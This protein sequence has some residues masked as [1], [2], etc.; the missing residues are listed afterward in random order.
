MVRLTKILNKKLTAVILA[1]AALCV[2]L[3]FLSGFFVGHIL[4]AQKISQI[5]KDQTGLE[6]KLCNSKISAMPDLS[7]LLS[8]KCLE[9]SLP[10]SNNAKN[11]SIFEGDNLELRVKIIPLLFK[12][13]SI[14]HFEANDIK[15]SV[16]R[17]KNGVF[18][19]EKYVKN[20][21]KFP[22]QLNFEKTA[23]KTLKSEMKF[24]D[25]KNLKIIILNCDKFLLSTS[26]RPKNLI[27]DTKGVVK[28]CDLNNQNNCANT[29]FTAFINTRLPF[30]KYSN[31]KNTELS[32][33]L[34]GFNLANLAPY[35]N[36]SGKIK[37]D[38]LTGLLDVSLLKTK[39]KQ[40][41]EFL[42]NVTSKD[43][44]GKFLYNKKNSEFKL[45]G[46]AVSNV[47]FIAQSQ[48]LEIL[49]SSFKASG[50]DVSFY[51]K[52]KNYKT[53]NPVPDI[54]I[55]IAQSDFMKFIHLVPAGF[56]VYKTDVIN[57]LI[58]A[59]PFAKMHG[60]LNISGNYKKPD[61]KGELFVE[62]IY[63]FERPKTFKTANVKC[64]FI[65]DKVNVDVH[66]PGPDNQFVDVRGFS[67]LYGRQAGDYDVISSNSVDL[68]F[69]HKYLI[70]VQRVIGFKLGPLPCMK[71]SGKGRIHIRAV[72]TIYDAIV[73]GKFF[74][75]GINA[76][77]AGLN[78]PLLNGRIELDFNGKVIDIKDTSAK[79]YDGD[80]IL[81]GRADDY[82][83]LDITAQIKNISASDALKIAK[84]SPLVKPISGDLSFIKSAEGKTDLTVV[85][86][87]KA[88]SLEGMG[89]LDDIHPYGKIVLN[90]VNALLE[91][92]LQVNRTNGSIDFS[93]DFNI[94]LNTVYR[95][96]N[97]SLSGILSPS[98]R[99]L[100]DK[101]TKIKFDVKTS[102]KSVLF[103]YIAKEAENMKYFG[104]QDLKFVMT[105]TPL[106]AIDFLFDVNLNAKGEIPA[107]Y[108]KADL[109][110]INLNGKFIPKNSDK[111]KNI[112]FNS[113]SY[114]LE[115]SRFNIRS[116]KIS[117][118]GANF[119]MDGVADNLFKKPR[120][121][122]KIKANGIK[123]ADVQNLKNYTSLAPFNEILKD[124]GDYSGEVNLDL[125]IKKNLPYGKISF[126]D[127]GA[128]NLKQQIR[129]LLKS[130]S[131]KFAGEKMYLD[132]LNFTYGTTPI[133]FD[134]SLKNYLSQN[135]NF[136]AML[137]TN[138]DE[139]AADRLINPYL[140]YPLKV[141]G[142]LRLKGRI[143]GDLNNYSVISY[144]N[145]PK[146]TDI[147]YMGA[148]AGDTEY[149]REFE[150][151]SDFTRNCA[152]VNSVKYI[153]YVHSQ[154]NKPT[155][156]VML[157]AYGKVVSKGKNLD[158]DNFRIVTQNPVTAKIFNVIFKK[159]VL[160]Q[161]LFTCDLRLFGNVTLPLA[162]G[163][164]SFQ[165][166]DMPLYNTRIS[167][168]NIDV[169]KNTIK[170]LMQGKSFDSDVEI[171]AVVKNKQTF[172]IVVEN[173]DIKS[174]NTSLSR[175]FEGISQFQKGSSD[176]VP[177]QPI[178][179]RPQDLVILKGSAQAQDVELYDIKAQNL[180]MNFSNP[181][182]YM[183]NI[184]DLRFDIAGGSVVSRGNFDVDSMLFD[185]DSTLSDCDANTLSKNFLGLDN[186]IY[187]RMN[188][189][190]NLKGK[191]PQN[192]QEI[193][194]V[195]GMVN[196]SVNNGKMPKLGSLEYLL[197]AGNLIKSGILGFTL[198]NL[199]EVLTPY[200]TGEFST[201]RG[202]FNLEE[203]KIKALEIFSKGGNL[204]LFI[205]GGYDIVN[206]N[207]DIEILGRLSKNI[208][209]LLGAAGNA[210]LNSL[211]N[212]LTGSKLKAGAK[213]Q[214]IDNVNKIPL[215]E[216][217]S[218]DYRLFL[219]KIKGKLNSED[220]VK[221]FNW[222]N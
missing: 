22:F 123:L 161:G 190:I 194:L 119:Y 131:I 100:T 171:S 52:I 50:I 145:L 213:S 18:N 164:I 10:G 169:G 117:L 34:N 134:A 153:K 175:L 79:L 15:I 40:K 133:Y 37:F 160:K 208:S 142:E 95:G 73:N 98:A 180:A 42:L 44:F 204:S 155:P 151:K 179:F 66:V 54:N 19:F 24:F 212:T 202:S 104:N 63:L 141:R 124:F 144:L 121:D 106:S 39:D 120:A 205:Y 80:F 17:D 177:G 197:R 33:A 156:V 38:N 221:S 165:N 53:K 125:N 90:S 48:A 87:G 107:D 222:L 136:N 198:N 122:L 139:V 12:K 9:I 187:G 110:K 116:S 210:S 81:K 103:S 154:N 72:G 143:R 84:T 46:E 74:G 188:A 147:T 61:V 146:D 6:L 200:K 207:A 70:P 140:T 128:V 14:K 35:I 192:A 105:N 214:I 113:G 20:S 218:Q 132:A 99:D 216:I 23:F 77:M 162:Q 178:V 111:S 26:K 97:I 114:E 31:S 96:S 184:D 49:P 51:G 203:G 217:S 28:F 211:I 170:A 149:D 118:F 25:E 5:V 55:K 93:K 135:P 83:N 43:V 168:M 76:S 183:F 109:S 94:N 82:N 167:D 11:E 181:S 69:A 186:Q 78:A 7:M 172:P 102:A 60:L 41:N 71:I 201:I 215:I 129:L 68:A 32:L 8:A 16:R 67:E 166:I 4:T 29:D 150:I 30:V 185:I 59:N 85:F 130:G 64:D 182:G 56:V 91:P 86:K 89:F 152:K 196:F 157:K 191:I 62:D 1:F 148:N 92:S 108:K 2:C 126:S 138:I 206:D 47:D 36:E 137:S 174:K 199:I 65:G 158:F 58:A 112:V 159:S 176:I 27:F 193:R 75:T 115:N 219:A 21:N 209:N 220:Y 189:D 57:E 13:I 101:N 195:T 45:A 88:K 127:A 163:K 173:L 3:Y